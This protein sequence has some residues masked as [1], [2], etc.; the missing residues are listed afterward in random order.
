[1]Q[2]WATDLGLAAGDWFV[3]RTPAG[4]V[5]RR[6]N[7]PADVI[8]EAPARELLLVLNRRLDPTHPGVDITG[9]HALFTYWL[10]HGRFRTCPR[11]PIADVSRILNT[12]SCTNRLTRYSAR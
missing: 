11:N 8:V 2:L 9:D 7:A 3:E 1:M 6:G 10:E 12:S 4:V 5:W